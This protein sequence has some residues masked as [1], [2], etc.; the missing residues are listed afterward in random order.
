MYF[1]LNDVELSDPHQS[2]RWIDGAVHHNFGGRS[3]IQA[4]LGPLSLRCSQR[5]ERKATRYMFRYHKDIDAGLDVS[6]AQSIFQRPY[7][8]RR[9][10]GSGLFFCL[11]DLILAREADICASRRALGLCNRSAGLHLTWKPSPH[12]WYIHTLYIIVCMHD[13]FFSSSRL[14]VYI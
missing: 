5:Y 2:T 9:S 4:T 13:S 14:V 8:S 10:S 11:G 7:V 12:P 3:S 6:W 1:Y